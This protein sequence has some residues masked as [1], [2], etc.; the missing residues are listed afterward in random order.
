MVGNKYEPVQNEESCA[1]LDALTEESGAHFETAGA[2]RGG[3]E[4]FVTLKLPES[5]VFDGRDGSK[6]RTDFYLAALNS[7]QVVEVPVPG[8]DRL[9]RPEHRRHIPPRD[10]AAVAVNDPFSDLAG[11]TKRP[12]LL[13]CSNRQQIGET[14]DH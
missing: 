12:A 1:L 7:R 9:P 14:N 10:P 6:D 13:A 2:L 8:P 4:T 5:M 3:R 11:I